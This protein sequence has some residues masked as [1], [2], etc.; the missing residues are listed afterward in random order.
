M[1]FC[2]PFLLGSLVLMTVI[3]QGAWRKPGDGS[4]VVLMVRQDVTRFL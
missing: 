4:V 2:L 1:P 3:V